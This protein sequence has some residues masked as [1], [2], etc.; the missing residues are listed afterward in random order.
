MYEFTPPSEI[1]EYELRLLHRYLSRAV[2]QCRAD[3]DACDRHCKYC[4]RHY[5][6]TQ[7]ISARDCIKRQMDKK[8]IEL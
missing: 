2:R 8:G 1:T 7:L 5:A 6:C 4:S 3:E